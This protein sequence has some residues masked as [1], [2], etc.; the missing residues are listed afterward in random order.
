MFDCTDGSFWSKFAEQQKAFNEKYNVVNETDLFEALN[1]E[2]NKLI[3]FLHLRLNQNNFIS[4]EELD[5]FVNN[6]LVSEAD[7]LPTPD[8]LPLGPL[9]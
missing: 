8:S 9:H 4:L 6:R 7:E 5:S 1:Y 2:G 3:Q